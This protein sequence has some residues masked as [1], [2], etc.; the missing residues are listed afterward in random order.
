MKKFSV[1]NH[2]SDTA[3]LL[4]WIHL[5]D[6]TWLP[7]TKAGEYSLPDT[8]KFPKSILDSEDLLKTSQKTKAIPWFK[9][10]CDHTGSDELYKFL[11]ADILP[12]TAHLLPSV[13][14]QITQSVPKE[15]RE[16]DHRVR[17]R[18]ASYFNMN[19]SLK[20]TSNILLALCDQSVS[21]E[22]TKSSIKKL[23]V[24]LKGTLLGS[25]NLTKFFAQ[26][27]LH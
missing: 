24:F 22:H 12:D 18:V 6:K 5:D 4:D 25:E 19:L 27:G 14:Q 3:K 1:P 16:R 20:L 9:F 26:E 7:G 10:E 21:L 11:Q 23:H 13:A 17:Q 8:Y 15:L 2:S